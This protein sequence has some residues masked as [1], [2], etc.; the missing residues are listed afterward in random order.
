MAF[1]R[2]FGRRRVTLVLLILTSVLL[3]TLDARD[4]GPINGARSGTMGFFAPVGDFFGTITRPVANI[5]NG[6]FSYD[7]LERENRQ[8]RQELSDL[9]S[10]EVQDGL[11]VKELEQLK[12]SLDIPF[13]NGMPSA[14]ARIVSG[15]IANFDDTVQVDKGSSNGIKRGMAVVSGAGLVGTV[16]EVADGFSMV[17]LIT[18]RDVQVGVKVVEKQGFAILNGRGDPHRLSGAVNK[19]ST[20]EV[21][22][23]LVTSGVEGSRYPEGIPVAR[24]AA[25]TLDEIAGKNDLEADVLVTLTDLEFVSV[26][27]VGGA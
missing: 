26:I 13:A 18:D 9:R 21:G 2:R 25:I 8:L 20:I 7:E 22:D 16:V 6:A 5:W 15:G 10:R 27:L 11:A 1:P 23:V 3:L 19:V 14:R 17:K 24:V 12:T 4:F